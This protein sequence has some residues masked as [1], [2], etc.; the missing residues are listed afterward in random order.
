M[1]PKQALA[2]ARK[3]WGKTAMVDFRDKAPLQAEKDTMDK[4]DNRRHAYRCNVGKEYRLPGLGAGMLNMGYG[5]TWE[6]AFARH[7]REHP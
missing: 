4:K 2:E 7:D 3:R 6:D 1:T 5:D